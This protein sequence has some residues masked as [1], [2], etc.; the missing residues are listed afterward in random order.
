MEFISDFSLYS[1]SYSSYCWFSP[2]KTGLVWSVVHGE[3]FCFGIMS[4][5]VFKSFSNLT[6]TLATFWIIIT[7]SPILFSLTHIIWALAAFFCTVATWMDYSRLR[8]DLD[9][10]SLKALINSKL[11]LAHISIEQLKLISNDFCRDHV[12]IYN[13]RH[14]ARQS[15]LISSLQIE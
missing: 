6:V 1:Y 15:L 13:T 5:W 3:I 4:P 12:V 9:E 8:A 14:M 2:E 7:M 11:S 10:V